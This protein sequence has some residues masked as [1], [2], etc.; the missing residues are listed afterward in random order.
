[1]TAPICPR[2]HSSLPQAGTHCPICG[3][4]GID[5]DPAKHLPDAPLSS[6]QQI[7]ALCRAYQHRL[8]EPGAL[9]E[10]YQ[11][12]LAAWQ[13]QNPFL[14]G[15]AK[16]QFVSEF[17]QRMMAATEWVGFENPPALTDPMRGIAFAYIRV[18]RRMAEHRQQVE[19]ESHGI[20]DPQ[21]P[22]AQ[23]VEAGLRLAPTLFQHAD[24]ANRYLAE[25]H[26]QLIARGDITDETLFSLLDRYWIN[27]YVG[28]F[29]MMEHAIAELERFKHAYHPRHEDSIIL[30]IRVLGAAAEGV[31][32]INHVP[33]ADAGVQHNNLI[34]ANVVSGWVTDAQDAITEGDL[35]KVVWY[36]QRWN[37]EPIQQ[38]RTLNEQ[39]QQLSGWMG[40]FPQGVSWPPRFKE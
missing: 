2:C 32:A 28:G 22:E 25:Y 8:D 12:E 33:A 21:S 15:V 1:M 19:A 16:P 35:G 5:P 20:V 38:F 17:G 29:V 37:P 26:R 30:A 27:A 10:R 24:M 7:L 40:L 9:M 34:L 14:S 6:P 23:E 18:Y 39:S 36:Y 13:R 11:M 31:K 4:G 3:Y